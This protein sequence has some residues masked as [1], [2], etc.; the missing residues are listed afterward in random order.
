M[1]KTKEKW[2]LTR[3]SWTSID[4]VLPGVWRRKEGGHVVRARVTNPRT[5]KRI[6]LWKVLPDLSAAEALHWLEQECEK[7]R[8]ETRVEPSKTRFATYAVSLL[9]R[10]IRARDIRSEAG[11]RKWQTCLQHLFRSPLAE[12]FI[13]KMRAQ[14][15]AD[16]R[17]AC[18]SMIAAG[19][20][21]PVTMNT[22]LS[23]LRVIM[24]TAR[25]ELVPSK[26]WPRST[27]ANTPLTRLKSPT[28]S[29]WKSCG[30]SCAACA[31]AFRSTT[32]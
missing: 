28:R 24:T 1:S 9:E 20:Y 4:P 6:E 30:R 29:P 17:D 5:G 23:V 18:A 11:I 27:R 15:F 12:L 13:E 32:R 10:K 26:A 2:K 16:W 3:G 8:T 14:D 19:R 21:S 25:I 7:V 31:N 22:D